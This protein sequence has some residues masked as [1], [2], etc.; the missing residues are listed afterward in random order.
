[1]AQFKIYGQ[2]ESLAGNRQQIS[3]VLHAAS[4][5][6]LGLPADKRFHRF[7]PLDA[8]SFI[9]PDSR[10]ERYTII[11]G[12]LFEGREVETKKSFYRALFEGFE[13]VLGIAA[14]DLEIVL[15]ETPRHDWGIRGLPGDEL[16]LD[17]KVRT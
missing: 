17:Y 3:D 10:S 9:Y 2:A 15:I 6:V 13:T 1:M 4:V 5:G 16:N 11:E 14:N 8:E 7:I 12:I